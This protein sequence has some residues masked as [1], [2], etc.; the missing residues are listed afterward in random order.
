[1]LTQETVTFEI[2]SIVNI[3]V[4]AILVVVSAYL[5]HV[6]AGFD[7]DIK[8]IKEQVDELV[9]RCYSYHGQGRKEKEDG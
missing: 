8:E 4:T 9:K 6:I 1:M 7:D 5:H 2:G 3:L